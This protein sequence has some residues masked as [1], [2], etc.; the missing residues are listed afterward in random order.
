MFGFG[1]VNGVKGIGNITGSS[2]SSQP[3]IT[4][5]AYPNGTITI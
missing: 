3:V 1:V 5:E 4:N 2:G